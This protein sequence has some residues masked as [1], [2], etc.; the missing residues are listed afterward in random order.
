VDLRTAKLLGKGDEMNALGTHVLAEYYD[1]NTN[2]LNN[3]KQIENCLNDAAQI[4]GATV[5]SSAFHT[6]NPHGVSGVVV[7]AESHL[8]IHTWPEYGYAAV[9]IFTCGDTVDPW[10][11]FEYLKK[12]LESGH[13]STIE[14]KRG[15]LGVVGQELKYKPDLVAVGG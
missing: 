6:F 14:M 15:Q 9:D 3:T 11:A 8:T 5:V 1:C 10:K 7:I 2:I 4:A 13:Y 12:N